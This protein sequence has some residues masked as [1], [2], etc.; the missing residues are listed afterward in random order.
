MD[1]GLKGKI[2]FVAAGSKGLGFATA[3]ALA[4][5]G[6]RIALNGRRE[7][8]LHQAAETLRERHQ[9]EVLCVP[10]DVADPDLP[11]KMI[12]QAAEKFG[13]LDLLFTNSG[14]LKPGYFEDL[15]EEDWNKAAQLCLMSHIRLIRAAL[16]WLKKSKSASVLTV[17]SISVKQPIANLL[18]SNSLRSAT[19]G[20][21]KSLALQYAPEGIRFNSILPGSTRTDRILQ[22]ASARAEKS[23]G[24][25]GEE[26]EKMGRAMPMGRL[27]EPEE[28]GKAAAFLL[29][30]AASYLTGVM[31]PVDGGSYSGTF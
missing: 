19:I 21:T 22:L 13:G 31:L 30:P 28:F 9:A 17:T 15:K 14:G 12:D 16:P 7:N 10:G 18:T 2:A 3:S 25:S 29:S 4:A 23:G 8:E 27:A 1:L 26:L 5:D 11:Q 24:T 20:L 6:C